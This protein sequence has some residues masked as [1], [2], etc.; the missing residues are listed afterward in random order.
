MR[1]FKE[2]DT[3]ELISL[4]KEAVSENK[5]LSFA[6]EKYANMTGRAKGSVRNYYYKTIK[7]CENDSNL[8]VKLGVSK[9]MYPAFI[10]EFNLAEEKELL[11]LILTGVASGKS[12]RNV[13]SSLASNSEK[14]AL[15]Y[16]NKYRN[17]L[18]DKKNLVLEVASNIKDKNGNAVNPYKESK[19]L[20]EKEKIESE[21]DSLLKRLYYELKSE[22]NKLKDK[23]LYL[24]KEN[25]KLKRIFKKCMEDKSFT[26]EY[27]DRNNRDILVL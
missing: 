12:V 16:Q 11:T 18:R 22:N 20:E 26:K 5:G 2:S 8:R 19:L 9:S 27:F 25:E 3:K 1:G 15:R 13:V 4:V 24:E 21:I 17:L 7:K 23:V 10:K 6:F 14:L